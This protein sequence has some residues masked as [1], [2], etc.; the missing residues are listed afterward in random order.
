MK[1]LEF[2]ISKD[3]SHTLFDKELNETYHST[4]G[5][6]QES[7]HVFI[8][9]GLVHFTENYSKITPNILEV[10]LGTGLNVLLVVLWAEKH[11]IN[12]EITSLEKYPLSTEITDQLNYHE[13]LEP[14]SKTILEKIH[15]SAWNETI[16][17][18][19]YVLFTKH[20][21]ELNSYTNP[22]HNLVFYDAFAPSKQPEMW[23]VSSL[24]KMKENCT[25]SAIFVTYCA[26]GQVRRDLEL[27]GFDISRIPGPP[28]KHEMLRGTINKQQ[29]I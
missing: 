1:N 8:E 4:H 17:L 22:K 6:I 28:G 12:L 29:I 3:G 9:S 23:T 21:I 10:G 2:I 26:K 14:E 11:K 24:K 27:I 19:E 13:F 15:S 16:K 5:A 18:S 25:E 20:D 7:K